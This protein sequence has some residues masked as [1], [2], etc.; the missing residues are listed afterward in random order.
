MMPLIEGHVI[1]VSAQHLWA[2][3][4]RLTDIAALWHALEMLLCVCL[5][6]HMI[7]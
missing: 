2:E 3:N 4:K 1:E 6:T 7:R 5:Q